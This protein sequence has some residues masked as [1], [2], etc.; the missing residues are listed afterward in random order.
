MIPDTQLLRDYAGAKSQDA[1]TE[2]VHRHLNLVYSAALRLVHSPQLAEEIS[3]SVFA[4]LARAADKLKPDTILTAW[5][6]Q[7]AR[8]TAI[9]VVRRES[10]RQARE[11]LAVE[12]ADMN[13]AATW[14]H[15]EPLLD[16][17]ME[18][19]DE[20]DRAAIL[21]RYFENKSLREVGQSLGTS[22]DAAQKRVSRAVERLR[23]FFSRRGVTIGVSGLIILISANSV[24]SAPLALAATIS[25][26]AILAGTTVHAS[27]A[28]TA[29]KAI[30]MTTLQKTLVTVAVAA[31]AGAGIY[32]ARQ[33]SQLSDQVRTLQRQQAPLSAQIQQL[34]NER[35]DA[36]NRLAAANEENALLKSGRG[37]DELLKLRSEVGMLRQQTVADT[38]TTGQTSGQ[39]MAQMMNNSQAKELAR[40]QIRQK[41]KGIYAPLVQKLNLSPEQTDQLYDLI[42]DNEL[43]KKDTLTKLLS[44]DVDVDT[45]LQARDS[46]AA[47]LENQIAGLLG[48]SSYAQFNQYKHDT[49]ASELVSGL[50]RELGSL[51]L[52]E[53]QSKRLQDLFEA[54]PDIIIDDTD[55]FRPKDSL[56]ALFQTLVDR[57]HHDL[58]QAASFLTPEQLAAAYT[59]QSNYF[60]T[61]RNTM[62]LGQQLVTKTARHITR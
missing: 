16:D 25:T 57:G 38:N 30:A 39:T 51:S 20:T 48:D 17:A 22:D 32:E 47:E 10:R 59:I 37:F 18:A 26:A 6:Y 2:L 7:V 41:L 8:R 23:E 27:T 46:G 13:T 4:D 60:N 55:L 50:N 58:E 28:I 33:V 54:K 1:F 34:Q 35:D 29:T 19:L 62:T 53:D 21:L 43:K 24:Q 31:L 61:I 52:N 56:D 44:G 9:D 11:R 12:M 42:V 5:L 15:I 45:A 36:T 40:V 49:A 3:Q 14:A